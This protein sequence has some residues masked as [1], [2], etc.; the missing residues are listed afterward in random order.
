MREGIDWWPDLHYMG[1][2]AVNPWY[3]LVMGLKRRVRGEE[4]RVREGWWGPGFYYMVN[5]W[6]N[7]VYWLVMM[8]REGGGEARFIQLG[9]LLRELSVLASC[10]FEEGV[11]TGRVVGDG[12]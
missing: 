2:L 1:Y 3:W 5:L 8:V 12:G 7:P 10:V 4:V 11:S 6:E 9:D